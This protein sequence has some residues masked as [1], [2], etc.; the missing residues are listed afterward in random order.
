MGVGIV[1]MDSNGE[2]MA[3][4]SSPKPFY[5]HPSVAEEFM[6]LQRALIFCNELCIEKAHFEGN[7][8]VLNNVINCESECLA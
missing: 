8:Q 4:L 1:L 7:A 3:C 6:A 2:V 5:S